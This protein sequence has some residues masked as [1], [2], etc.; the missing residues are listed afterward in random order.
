MPVKA[1]VWDFM[2]QY[3]RQKKTTPS[4]REIQSRFNLSTFILQEVMGK[5]VREGYV[6][7]SDVSR[8]TVFYV[9]LRNGAYKLA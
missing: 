2:N 8:H 1:Q 9:L 3:Y 6:R 4:R 7:K 5:L